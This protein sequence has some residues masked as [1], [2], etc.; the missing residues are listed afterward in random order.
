MFINEQSVTLDVPPKVIDGRTLLPIRAVLEAFGHSLEWDG[1]TKTVN[2]ISK[3]ANNDV[4]I[5]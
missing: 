1:A 4:V 2:V 5:P 3:S